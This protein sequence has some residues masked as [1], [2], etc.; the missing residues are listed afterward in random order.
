M[1]NSNMDELISGWKIKGFEL[2]HGLADGAY[3]EGYVPAEAVDM[4]VP[5]TVQTALLNAGKIPDPYQGLNSAEI[6]WIEKMEWWHFKDFKT[7]RSNNAEQRIFVR[8]EGITYRAEVW[9]NGI[10]VGRIEGM[11]RT[12]EFDVT[13]YVNEEGKDNRLTLRI[14]A[15]ENAFLDDRLS[16]VSSKI[17]TQGAVAQNMTRWNWCQHLVCIGIWRPVKLLIKSSVEIDLIRI[18]TLS[19][20]SLDKDG[21]D[22]PCADAMLRLE[23]DIRN[24]GDKAAKVALAFEIAGETFSGVVAE[25]ELTGEIMAGDKQTLTSE[26][27]VKQAR[28]WWPN[29]LG[30]AEL[31]R[32]TSSLRGTDGCDIEKKEDV[33]GIRKFSFLRNE[34]E[35]WVK[36]TSGHSMRPW[37]M[38]GE[39]YKWTF[40]VNGRKVFLKGS[41]WVM[42]D[43]LL[44]LES[45]RYDR[46]LSVAQAGGINFLRVWGGSLAETD[47]F[48]DLCDRYGIM[49]WQ[50]F[51]LACGN[52]PAMNHE[53]FLRCVKDTVNRLVNRSSL[54]YY[55]GG[56]EYEPDNREN[57]V[58]VDKIEKLVAELDTE[59]EFR[60]GSPYKGDK[61]GGLVMTPLM[62]RNKYLDILPGDSRVVLMR[63]EVAT[64]RSAPLMSSLEKMIPE[65]KRW[66]MDEKWWRN[67]FAVPAEFKMFA[68]EYDAL[69]NLRHATFANHFVHGE[70]CRYNMEYCRTQMFTCSGNLNWQLNA[71][72]PCM[73]RE[74]VEY[75]GVP[76][77]AFYWHIN[78][79]KPVIGVVD[80]ERYLWHPGE[81]FS[82]DLHIANDRR[83]LKDAQF[84]VK[85]YST[86]SELLHS[87]SFNVDVPENAAKKLKD[88]IRFE[89]PTTLSEKTIFIR[90]E[91][92][93][94]NRGVHSNLYWI[95]VSNN[96][97]PVASVSLCGE[98]LREDGST[99]SLPGN[100]LAI[101]NK[102][103]ETVF[104]KDDGEGD[105]ENAGSS[106]NDKVSCDKG[107]IVYKKTF[108]L[109][110]NLKNVE[111]EFYSPGFEAS[112]EVWINGVKIG[113]HDFKNPV[114]STKEWTFIPHGKNEPSYDIDPDSEYFFYSDPITFAKLESRFYDI[115]SEILNQDGSNEITLVIKTYY[116]KAVSNIMDIRPGTSRRKE[117]NQFFKD[118]KFFRDLRKMPNADL[119]LVNYCENSSL[120]IKNISEQVAIG[121]TIEFVSEAS[122]LP[123]ALDNNSFPLFPGEEKTLQ[124][125]LDNENFEFPATIRMYGWN[126]EEK[127]I[128]W[129]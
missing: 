97:V 106:S 40:V 36:A 99:V 94:E 79:C 105:L 43:S 101:Q 113:S 82:P 96:P 74:V 128:E 56:N 1:K 68:N 120:V 10:Q 119:E 123:M 115:P 110:D 3:Q 53:V 11:F 114:F 24:N 111:L 45:E 14:R 127:T 28:L 90:T 71:P 8:F 57:K 76:K 81:V 41:N 48:Y 55:S 108:V 84:S 80:I 27:S 30:K 102:S 2:E 89:I 122:G 77:P 69:D 47:E 5:S 25:G 12:D 112:D 92:S 64:G 125:L 54:I 116:Q 65:D 60:R 46:V 117:I 29:G 26:I 17:R 18:K 72:W 91:L 59:R 61:H 88:K 23:W 19:V 13:D 51:W 126:V 73:H 104:C 49:C 22:V 34:R 31:H 50:E 129:K 95:A 87:A 35:D 15:Q 63:S 21:G 44:R 109:P 100:D 103:F 52:Y 7:P 85:L 20:D 33:F 38:I 67:F 93:V 107:D 70:L 32:L 121:V 98:W 42:L 118:G 9:V 39:L 6:K 75:N 78:A 86:D 124:P 83:A 4:E 16:P 37:S 58:L 66:P 62:T